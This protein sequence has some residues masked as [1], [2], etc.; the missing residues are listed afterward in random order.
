[1]LG[2]V[3]DGSVAHGGDENVRCGGRTAAEKTGRRGGTAAPQ[4]DSFDGGGEDDEA[5]RS[6]GFDLRGAAP[7]DGDELRCLGSHGGDGKGKKRRGEGA[8][9]TGMGSSGLEQLAPVQ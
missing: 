4:H 8:M 2:E 7:H 6:I 5:E 1:M 3:K 9:A